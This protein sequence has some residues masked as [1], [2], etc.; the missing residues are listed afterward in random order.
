MYP[1]FELNLCLQY[2]LYKFPTET[3]GDTFFCIYT[4]GI[5][6]NVR[7]LDRH[8]GAA[9][10]GLI[11]PSESEIVLEFS[12]ELKGVYKKGN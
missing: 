12:F 11:Q 6:V 3:F 2:K 9:F 4:S 1:I 5:L 10:G 8:V 7:L